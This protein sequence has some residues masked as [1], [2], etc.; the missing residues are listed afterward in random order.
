MRSNAHSDCSDVVRMTQLL[1]GLHVPCALVVAALDEKLNGVGYI[2]PGLGWPPPSAHHDPRPV[3][4]IPM[5]G[6]R[7]GS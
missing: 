2:A 4:M 7:G 5:H 6:A 1:D 3:T